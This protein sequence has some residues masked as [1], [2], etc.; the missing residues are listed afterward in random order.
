V[1][2]T[3]AIILGDNDFGFVYYNLLE[4][5]KNLIKWFDGTDPECDMQTKIVEFIN[6]SSL[7]FYFA[8]NNWLTLETFIEKRTFMSEYLSEAKILFNEE[9][10]ED[11]LNNYHDYGAWYLEVQS[12]K[13]E[14][15]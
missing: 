8:Y 3:V 12:G 14:S 4:S 2:R 9:A 6:Q 5:V 13:I 1:I 10:E 15:Y 11:I 7:A